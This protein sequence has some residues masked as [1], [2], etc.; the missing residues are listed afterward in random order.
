MHGKN[1]MLSCD[2]SVAWSNLLIHTPEFMAQKILIC[3]VRTDGG[4]YGKPLTPIETLES[5]RVG[6]KKVLVLAL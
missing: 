3:S 2:G 6:L 5:K 1:S 4:S